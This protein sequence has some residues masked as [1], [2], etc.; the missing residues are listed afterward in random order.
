[1][2]I[3]LLSVVSYSATHI[4]VPST[5]IVISKSLEECMRDNFSDHAIYAL[6]TYPKYCLAR[7]IQFWERLIFKNVQ[8]SDLFPG[9][10]LSNI[11][12]DQQTKIKIQEVLTVES[13]LTHE[14]HYVRLA[15]KAIIEKREPL[16]VIN[17][18]EDRHSDRR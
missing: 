10:C 7:K 8:Q 14:L 12:A 13:A 16:D 5:G 1:M 2:K 15:A 9:E 18:Y 4:G 11:I 6:T 3:P 17:E